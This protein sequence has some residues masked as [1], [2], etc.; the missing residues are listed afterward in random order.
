MTFFRRLIT[1]IKA[2][3]KTEPQTLLGRWRYVGSQ[4]NDL[5]ILEIKMKNKSKRFYNI[6]ELREKEFSKLLS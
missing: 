3:Y 5:D 6:N 2:Q 4:K 1:S